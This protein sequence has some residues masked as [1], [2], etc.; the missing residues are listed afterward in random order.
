MVS[1]GASCESFDAPQ[2]FTR[3]ASALRE[4]RSADVSAAEMT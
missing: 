4:M 3:D 2:L 1:V